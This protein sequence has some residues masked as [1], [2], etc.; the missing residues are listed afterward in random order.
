MKVK[1]GW[2]DLPRTIVHDKAS[3]MVTASH[4]QL[5]VMFAGALAEAGF[6]SWVGPEMDS[7]TTWLVKKFGDVYLHERVIAHIRRLLD[8]DFASHNLVETLAQFRTRVEKVEDYMN[9]AAFPRNEGLMGLAE[10]SR[11]R[12]EEV[13]KR[14]GQGVPK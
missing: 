11:D 12:C 7:P 9:S 14:K 2:S 6:K 3:Y 1:H 4:E 5:H 13:V 10:R 8:T